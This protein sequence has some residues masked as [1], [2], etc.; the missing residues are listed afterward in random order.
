MDEFG[1]LFRCRFACKIA[2]VFGFFGNQIA[3]AKPL[4]VQLCKNAMALY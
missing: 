1:F 3:L 4:E 2:M